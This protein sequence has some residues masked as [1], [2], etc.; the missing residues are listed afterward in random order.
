M[1]LLPFPPFTMPIAALQPATDIWLRYFASLD[2]AVRSAPAFQFPE[3]SLNDAAGQTLTVPQFLA[4]VLL[5]SGPVGA[6]SDTTP[7]AEQIVAAIPKA[8]IGSNRLT[9]IRNGGGGTMTLLA[10]SGVTLQGT[11]TIAAGNAR[12]YLLTVTAK[13]AGAEAVNVRGLLTGA[14]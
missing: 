10:G 4:A 6:F 1:M 3:A 14:M 5:R 12:F 8:D 11:T 7:T 13:T 2:Q 9:L